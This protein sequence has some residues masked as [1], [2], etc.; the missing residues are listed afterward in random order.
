M[1]KRGKAKVEAARVLTRSAGG[2]QHVQLRVRI[3]GDWM[4]ENAAIMRAAARFWEMAPTLMR[5][6]KLPW[7]VNVTT[8]SA[9]LDLEPGDDADAEAYAKAEKLIDRLAAEV[10]GRGGFQ[11]GADGSL[12]YISI[13]A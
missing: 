10:E 3:P 7:A 4:A 1:A 13:P 9:T 8:D 5:N 12:F 6:G 11:R 2:H